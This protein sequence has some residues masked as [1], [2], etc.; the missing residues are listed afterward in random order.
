[1]HCHGTAPRSGSEVVTDTET[2]FVPREVC[3]VEEARRRNRVSCE[4]VALSSGNPRADPLFAGGRKEGV[5]V[6][7]FL[8]V[9]RRVTQSATAKHISHC[10]SRA[11]ASIARSGGCGF[12]IDLF[13]CSSRKFGVPGIGDTRTRCALGRRRN[14]RRTTKRVAGVDGPS[15]HV[16][17]HGTR[18]RP[19]GSD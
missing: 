2:D 15:L 5:R 19:V 8:S 18:Q 17:D 6:L 7:L 11:A 4:L 10:I 14:P 13:E 16:P 9:S 3:E 12:H 1:L